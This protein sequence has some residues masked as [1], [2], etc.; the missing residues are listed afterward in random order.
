MFRE[1]PADAPTELPSDV[2]YLATP[3]DSL[4][5][6]IAL[7]LLVPAVVLVQLYVDNPD[8]KIWQRYL[9]TSDVDSLG[10]RIYVGC[11]GFG[12]EIHRHLAITERWGVPCWD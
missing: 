8:A 6:P 2:E 5:I 4:G 10:Q 11:S 7:E 9:W 1:L 3:P 12:L